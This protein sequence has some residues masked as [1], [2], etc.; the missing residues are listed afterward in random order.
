MDEPTIGLDPT[1]K[2]ILWNLVEELHS[3]GRTIILCSHDMYE[4]ELLCDDVGIINNGVLAAFNTPQALKDAM[5]NE[6]KNVKNSKRSNIAKIVL[7]I[8][9]EATPV[10]YAAYDKIK[11]H[12]EEENR[13]TRQLSVIISNLNDELFNQ[14]KNLSI[15][16]NITKQSSGRI[17]LDIL[18][19]DESVTEVISTIIMNNGI[20]TSISTKDPSLED[21]FVKVTAKK[22]EGGEI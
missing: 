3:E 15:T 6:Q 8:Q 1:T 7:E 16:Y 14:L 12:A 4:V 19:S 13:D 22:K 20:I 9:K 2:R 5:I 17:T 10:E 11:D 21:V 18:D